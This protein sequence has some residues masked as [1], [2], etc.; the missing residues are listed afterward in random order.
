MS[1]NQR[2]LELRLGETQDAL[3]R[4]LGLLQRRRCRVVQV[5][6]VARDRHYPG[7]L[8]ICVEP[9]A[10]RA[11]ILERWLANLVDVVAVESQAP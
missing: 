10:G 1:T 5:D 6:F 4:V 7:R 9:P 2:H 11:D 8:V 3:V